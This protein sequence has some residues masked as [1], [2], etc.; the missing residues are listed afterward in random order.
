LPQSHFP[1]RVPAESRNRV[2]CHLRKC[3]VDASTEFMFLGTP[4]RELFPNAIK[5][6][7]E[8]L[9]LPLGER[10]TLD[11]VKVISKYVTDSLR[12]HVN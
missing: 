4:H 6:S 1:I 5:A 3:G 10:V 7:Q 8:V 9:A 2:R 12:A 11:E